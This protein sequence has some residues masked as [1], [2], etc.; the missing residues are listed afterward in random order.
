M[1]DALAEVEVV[2]QFLGTRFCLLLVL[3]GYE[4]RDADVFECSELGKELVELEDKAEVLIAETGNVFIFETCD[5]D[6]IDGDGTTVGCVE[7]AHDLQK[8]GLSCS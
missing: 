1:V 6:A 7:G 4:G 5:V 8:G 3:A 2:E